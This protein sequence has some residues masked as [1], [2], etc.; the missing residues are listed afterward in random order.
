[1]QAGNGRVTRSCMRE[2]ILQ[3]GSTGSD[4]VVYAHIDGSLLK[5]IV[6][7]ITRDAFV[8]LFAGTGTNAYRGVIGSSWRAYVASLEGEGKLGHPVARTALIT[9]SAGSQVAMEAC[10]DADPPDA[11]VMLDGLYAGKPKG[12]V[13]GDGQVIDNA[14]LDA[15]V[16]C[17]VAAA[18]REKSPRDVE[19]VFVIFH[20]RIPTP[21]ASSKECAERVQMRVELALG[22]KMQPATDVRP[23]LLDGHF[24]VEALALGNLRI[25]EFAGANAGEHIK[26]AHLWDEAV[27]L[28]L[29]WVT[30]TG[31][32]A[33]PSTAWEVPLKRVLD[34]QRPM[35]RGKDVRVWQGFLVRQGL[36]LDVDG[37]FGPKTSAQTQVWQRASGLPETGKLDSATYHAAVLAG[38]EPNGEGISVGLSATNPMEEEPPSTL[39]DGATRVD[40]VSAVI[41]RARKDIGVGEDFGHNDGQRIREM[42]RRFGFI[43]GSNWCAIAVS[44]WL[45]K[46]AED[47]G[48]RSPV[49]GSQGA[50]ALMGQFKAAGRWLPASDARKSPTLVK[51][52]MVPVWDRSDPARPESSWW[53]HIGLTTSGADVLGS[54]STIEGNSGPKGDRVVENKRLLSEPKLFGFGRLV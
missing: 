1:M 4:L 5:P 22:E 38:F 48:V 54:F 10:A 20:S 35:M 21:Y 15:V 6:P 47:A 44:D 41:A 53:G 42:G 49:Q 32:T 2:T 51:A 50:Q 8:T 46:G 36:V 43:P 45:L 31:V 40:L 30:E 16:K 33:G 52:G 27:K 24:F 14:G 23:E 11:V 13:M 19:R 26:E 9:W 7:T 39:P 3:A 28:W 37:L 17:A 12:S 25:V 18:R 29:P 34:V